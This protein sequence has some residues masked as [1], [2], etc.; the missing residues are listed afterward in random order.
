MAKTVCVIVSP[1]DRRHGKPN[2]YSDSLREWAYAK[3]VQNSAERAVIM[4]L[5]ITDYNSN[6]PHSALGGRPP[7]TWLAAPRA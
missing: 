2:A 5:W 6:R 4:P 3:P 7:L 1:S